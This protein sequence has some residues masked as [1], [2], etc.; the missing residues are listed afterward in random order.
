MR[1]SGGRCRDWRAVHVVCATPAARLSFLTTCLPTRSLGRRWYF[2]D[3]PVATGTSVRDGVEVGIRITEA[4]DGALGAMP[5]VVRLLLQRPG[6]AG[7]PVTHAPRVLA[8]A[9]FPC[10]RMP[11]WF[12]TALATGSVR[13]VRALRRLPASSSDGLTCSEVGR[14]VDRLFRA[15]IPNPTWRYFALRWCAQWLESPAVGRTATVPGLGSRAGAGEWL[16]SRHEYV[17][18]VVSRLVHI[19]VVRLWGPSAARRAGEERALL[20]DLAAEIQS[21]PGRGHRGEPSVADR[22]RHH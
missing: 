17:A 21:D 10:G 18:A 3:V 16:P 15:L 8:P 4:P 2:A 1:V 13:A 5:A 22:W 14:E 7:A 12:P 11:S 6:A 9:L 19:H 20:L